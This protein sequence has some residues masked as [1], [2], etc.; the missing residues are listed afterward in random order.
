MTDVYRDNIDE[1]VIDGHRLGRYVKH[2]ARSLRFPFRTNAQLVSTAWTDHIDVLN[3]G[4]LGS[5]TG[6]ATVHALGHSPFYE[7]LTD[8]LK[9]SLT[10][11]SA[12]KIYSLATQLDDF[13]GT[14][15]PTDTGSSGLDAAKAAVH[16]GYIS[17]YNHALSLHDALSAVMTGPIIVGVMWY[18]SFD[19]PRPDGEMPMDGYERGGHEVCVWQV[20]VENERVWIKN[21]WGPEWGVNGTAWWSFDTF[22]KLLDNYGDATVFVPLT[23]P[24]P[25]PIPVPVPVPEPEPVP[26]PEPQVDCIPVDDD[27]LQKLV[28]A[29]NAWERSIISR[30]TKAGKLKIAFDA[31]KKK[32]NL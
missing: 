23:V 30:I 22:A 12:V 26:V 21:S 20:D 14:Y 16:Y 4:E 13:Y 32:F 25:T 3:Q 29:G 31:F 8:E 10:E 17:G 27:A 18:S 24:A 9:V 28:G 6:N 19:V 11:D 5:C 1:T 7:T 15:P 2:D